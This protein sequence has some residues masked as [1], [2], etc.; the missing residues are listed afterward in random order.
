MTTSKKYFKITLMWAAMIAFCWL[1]IGLL[2]NYS[3]SHSSS[4]YLNNYL[5]RIFGF[6][7]SILYL[8]L[9]F[10]NILS[11]AIYCRIMSKLIDMNSEVYTWIL[12]AISGAALIVNTSTIT[13]I[14]LGAVN[15]DLGYTI[16]CLGIGL[17]ASCFMWFAFRWGNAVTRN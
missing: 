4:I 13:L 10:M 8:F 11:W 15:D 6:G 14:G 12:R 3:N 1:S 2:V 7:L 9:L 5:S 17:V 16:I